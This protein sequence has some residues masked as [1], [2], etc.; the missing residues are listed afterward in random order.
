MSRLFKPHLRLT[1]VVLFIA[2]LFVTSVSLPATP[3]RATGCTPYHIVQPGENLFRVGLKYGV[4]W[5]VLARLNGIANPSRILIGQVICLPSNLPP[6]TPIVVPVVVPTLVPGTVF[7]PAAG[8]YPYIDFDRRVAATGE[9][10]QIKGY[11]FPGNATVDVFI[12]NKGF[13]Y[14]ATPSAS[15]TVAADGTVVINFTIPASVDTLLLNGPQLSVK[16]IARVSGYYGFNFFT[17]R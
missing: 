16:V 10:I 3:V 8:V 14:P 5:V 11:R 15:A 1:L 12:T 13:A 7:V 9:T 2:A 4:S 6:V 17:R